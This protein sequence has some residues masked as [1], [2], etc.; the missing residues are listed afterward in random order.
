MQ[1]CSASGRI[2][3][4]VPRE[5]QEN[6]AASQVHLYPNSWQT[7]AMKFSEHEIIFLS[8]TSVKNRKVEFL[9]H[10][11]YFV[12]PSPN[13]PLLGMYLCLPFSVSS[14]VTLTPGFWTLP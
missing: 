14:H 10:K 6:C 3:Q 11:F 12:S 13:L 5:Q 7:M 4:C 9:T 8:L 1:L 2:Q